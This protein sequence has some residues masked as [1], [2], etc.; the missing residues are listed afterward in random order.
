MSSATSRQAGRGTTM[1]L[2]AILFYSAVS[3]M[4]M[5]SA[6]SCAPCSKVECPLLRHRCPAKDLT[7]DVCGCCTVCAQ[8]LNEKCG[9]PF[10]LYGICSSHLECETPFRSHDT[11]DELEGVCKGKYNPLQNSVK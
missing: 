6:L 9:G 1:T 2:W 10:G 3:L 8:Q 7:S 4:A 5:V 11:L